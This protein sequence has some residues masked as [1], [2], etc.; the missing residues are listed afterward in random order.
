VMA[1][2]HLPGRTAEVLALISLQS[3][4]WIS[5]GETTKNVYRVHAPRQVYDHVEVMLA[6]PVSLSAQVQVQWQLADNA[7]GVDPLIYSLLPDGTR[8]QVPIQELPEWQKR[9]ERDMQLQM[10]TATA[11]L[12][13]P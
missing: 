13:L 11:M 12:D 3:P 5:P 7:I 4:R 8:S 6:L 9:M 1:E 10:T 2:R